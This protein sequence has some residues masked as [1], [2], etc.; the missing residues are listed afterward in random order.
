VTGQQRH[1]DRVA[2]SGERL[3]QRTHRLRVAGEAVQHQ[4]ADAATLDGHRFGTRKDLGHLAP[5]RCPTVLPT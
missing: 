3:G 5:F 4:H 1:L 2:G